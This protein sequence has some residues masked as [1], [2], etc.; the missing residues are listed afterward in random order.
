M[1]SII[2]IVHNTA[3]LSYKD[4]QAIIIM[5]NMWLV[6]VTAI[7][8]KVPFKTALAVFSDSLFDVYTVDTRADMH[9]S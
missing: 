3:I 6:I 8:L 2:I 4:E 1:C 5:Y 7:K 9:G